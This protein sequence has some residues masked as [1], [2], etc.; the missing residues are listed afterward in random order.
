LKIDWTALT[1]SLFLSTRITHNPYALLGL[2]P[3]M[4]VAAWIGTSS[5]NKSFKKNNSKNNKS[6]IQMKEPDKIK[7]DISMSNWMD[8]TQRKEFEALAL[9][10]K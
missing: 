5:V 6:F 1:V 9:R 7:E 2:I 4:Y 3:F 10:K 8:E